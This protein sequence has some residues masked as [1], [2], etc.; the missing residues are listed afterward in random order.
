MWENVQGGIV[1]KCI[2]MLFPFVFPLVTFQFFSQRLAAPRGGKGGRRHGGRDRIRKGG[3]RLG[4]RGDS[5]E[6]EGQGYSWRPSVDQRSDRGG[7]LPCPARK[8]SKEANEYAREEGLP[9]IYI[10]RTVTVAYESVSFLQKVSNV[11]R[12]AICLGGEE[13]RS[14]NYINLL[15]F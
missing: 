3:G 12:P 2:K 10:K 8:Q 5:A 11:H 15:E 4:E 1:L 7:H 14:L 13:D 9:A 6:E